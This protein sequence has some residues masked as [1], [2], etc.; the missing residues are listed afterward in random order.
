MTWPARTITRGSILILLCLLAGA[1]PLWQLDGSFKRRHV[2]LD[3]ARSKEFLTAG[4][5]GPSDV[6]G[7]RWGG[8]TNL[9]FDLGPIAKGDV[10]KLNLRSESQP[11]SL[12]LRVDSS[13]LAEVPVTTAW[14]EVEIVTPHAGRSLS[15]EATL[16]PLHISRVSV[17]NVLG[18]VNGPVEA[19]SVAPIA[20]PKAHLRAAPLM[21][22]PLTFGLVVLLWRRGTTAAWRNAYLVVA[23]AALV[24]GAVTVAELVGGLR[25]LYPLHTYV[26]LVVGSALAV[27]YATR[28]PSRAG[29]AA[30]ARAA[31]TCLCAVT[32]GLLA[33]VPQP[34]LLRRAQL[35]PRR[36]VII[37]AGAL[38]A[39][40]AIAVGFATLVVRS[41]DGPMLGFGDASQW[42]H[43]SHYVYHNLSFHPLPTLDLDNDQLWYPY[44]GSNV[45]M[46]WVLE[47]H[48]FS[49]CLRTI[50]GLGPW[51]Q[52]YLVLS[53]LITACGAWIL[54][55]REYSLLHAIVLAPAVSYCNYYAVSR[56][57]GQTGISSC[58]WIVLGLLLDFVLFHR[59]ILGKP[60]SSRILLARV[61]TLVLA[62]GLDL[63]YQCGIALTSALVTAIAVVVVGVWR[64]RGRPRVL[65]AR[66]SESVSSL[67]TDA[68]RHPFASLTLLAVIAVAAWLYIPLVTQI[69][70]E[71]S[72]FEG[73]AMVAGGVPMGPRRLLHPVLPGW[74][75]IAA[76]ANLSDNDSLV[77]RP[78]LFFVA[79][80]VAGLA[81]AGR[82]RSSAAPAIVVLTLLLSFDPKTFTVLRGLPWFATARNATRFSTVLPVLLA[83]P[84]LA[85]PVRRLGRRGAGLVVALLVMLLGVEATT[86]YH[87][88]IVRLKPRRLAP[89][90]ELV[91][92]LETVSRTPGEAVLEWPFCIAGGNGVGTKLLGRFYHL[93]NNCATLQVF[94][95]KKIMGKYF[96]RLD[97]TQIQP[98]LNA[99][100]NK[101]F[102]PDDPSPHRARRQLRGF[103]SEEWEFFDDFF[104]LNDFCG[105][106][107]Y[108]DLLP[109]A[110][111][112]EIRRRYG[113]PSATAR[114]PRFGAIEFIPKR[115]EMRVKVDPVAGRSLTF[116][117]G[118]HEWPLGSRMEMASQACE[119]FLCEGWAPAADGFRTLADRRASLYF[120]LPPQACQLMAN[121]RAFSHECRQVAVSLNGKVIA[122]SKKPA[123]GW[124]TYTFGVP[125]AALGAENTLS[126]E[127]EPASEGATLGIAW[128]DL[129]PD[130]QGAHDTETS[131]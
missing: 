21:L 97:P 77:G 74:K 13:P 33:G 58:H 46:P 27:D 12:Q 41:F 126:F 10:I 31:T 87:S 118:P 19:Y 91:S 54:L 15:F 90:A 84:A 111:A 131:D 63:G 60:W 128:I 25:L 124:S 53:F 38:L 123:S 39:T 93:Q 112:A 122:E 14:H 69:A 78:G 71:V 103:S 40:L 59:T 120:A 80:A 44:G 102:A 4:R 119:G 65:V 76:A 116:R 70:G 89:T 9:T 100:W 61:A 88:R 68:R 56:C 49:S 6:G 99:G 75:S 50:F 105:I 35:E 11:V 106:L 125:P 8:S 85:I 81:F 42:L 18:W 96:G 67:V 98:F 7:A 45:F 37:E 130:S 127:I 28:G 36:R 117:G 43:Q 115:P 20:P 3:F 24:S 52:L 17:S 101:L 108:P 29:A 83:I 95:Q 47:L 73:E 86:A 66:V 34:L 129:A 2:T 30:L 22:L 94:H 114:W 32:P 23:P 1:A 104:M 55:Y 92:L 48:L 110:A 64:S 113:P 51:E 5:L 79:L 72:R 57:P 16:H 82:A 107:L 121:I 62:F 109:R 26:L